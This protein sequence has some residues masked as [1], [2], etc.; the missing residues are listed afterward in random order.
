MNCDS[1]QL[2]DELIILKECRMISELICEIWTKV[3]KIHKR[4]ITFAKSKQLG[5]LAVTKESLDVYY[6]YLLTSQF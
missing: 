6:S 3:L 2:C 4:R 5:K 1:S